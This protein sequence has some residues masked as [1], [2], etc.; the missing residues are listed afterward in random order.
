MM[1]DDSAPAIP[2]RLQQ[3]RVAPLAD[4]EATPEQAAAMAPFASGGRPLLNIFRTLGRVPEALEAFRP[5]GSYV[6]SRRNSLSARQR[7]IV[8]LRVGARCRAGYE[9]AQHS[10]IGRHAGLSDAEIERLRAGGREGWAA[11]EALLVQAADEIVAD[12]FVSDATWAGL[13]AQFTERQ[14]MDVVFTAA[15][16]VLVSTFLNSFGVQLES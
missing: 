13:C 4:A 12:Q 7:E 14:A 8:I 16:Y 6:L 10:R 15:A 3:P 11:D 9:F 1:P 2:L 5:W